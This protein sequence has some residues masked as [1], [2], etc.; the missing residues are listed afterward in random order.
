MINDNVVPCLISVQNVGQWKDK[1]PHHKV[2]QGEQKRVDYVK[3]AIVQAKN[4]YNCGVFK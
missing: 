3:D 4:K 1:Q 2:N